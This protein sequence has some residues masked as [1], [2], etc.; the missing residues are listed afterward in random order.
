[1]YYGLFH[2]PSN[3]SCFATS[4]I[5]YRMLSFPSL[6]ANSRTAAK[7]VTNLPNTI[8]SVP[9]FKPLED[10]TLMD[11]YMFAAVMRDK[12]NL[13]PLLECILGVA[14]TDI[15]FVEP[16]KTEKE[17]YRSHGIRLGLYVR[18]DKNRIF[19]VA[20][21]T[22]SKKNLPKRIRYYQFTSQPKRILHAK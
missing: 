7:E 14:I 6:S 18:D 8:T 22:S 2:Y 1:M 21:Q 19:N 12:S 15:T 9:C 10:L 4:D 3:V 17:G 16:Q 13:K 20:V 11:N 5:I